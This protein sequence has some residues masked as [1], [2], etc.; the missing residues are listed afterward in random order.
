[1]L[2]RLIFRT[3]SHGEEWIKRQAYPEKEKFDVY[4][5][6]GAS[7][8]GGWHPKTYRARRVDVKCL[9]YMMCVARHIWKRNSCWIYIFLCNSDFLD[10]FRHV[11]QVLLTSIW[12]KLFVDFLE[13]VF[14]DGAVRTLLFEP[15]VHHPGDFQV[16][17]YMYTCI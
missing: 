4:W 8:E 12:E 13:C 1:M 7:K 10:L 6:C 15:S 2:T 9:E 16:Y 5:F 3:N 11:I 17:E 14:V